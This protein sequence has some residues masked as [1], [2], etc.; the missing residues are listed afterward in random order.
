MPYLGL[1]DA[2]GHEI[3]A[4]GY[5]RIDLD[6]YVFKLALYRQTPTFLFTNADRIKWRAKARGWPNVYCICGFFDENA[7]RPVCTSKFD[8]PRQN[9]T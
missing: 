2:G 4:S 7:K 1:L 3:K 6:P 8:K 5:C 9:T